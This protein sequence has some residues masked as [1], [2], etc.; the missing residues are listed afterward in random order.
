M[1]MSGAKF[2]EVKFDGTGNF[3]LWQTRVKD[4]LAQ[5]GMLKA[6]RPQKHDSMDDE[7]LEELQQHAARTIRLCLADEITYHVMNLK[8]SGEE[9]SDLAQ[10]VKCL[11]SNNHRSRTS[12]A[13]RRSH[14]YKCKVPG[15]MKIDCPKLKR[16]A[17]EKCDDLSKS[18][19]VVHNDNSDCYDGDML[20]ISTN[21]FVDAWILDSGCF[22]HITPNREWFTSCRSRNFGSVYLGD[23]RCCNIVGTGEV[24]IK[25]YDSTIRTL[26]DVRHIPDLKKNLT[27]FGNLHKNGFIPKDDEDRETIGIVKGALT[28]MK[29]KITAGNIYKLL[30]STVQHRDK[31]PENSSSSDTLQMELEPHPVATESG[32]S[33]HPTSGGSTID[34]LQTYNLDRDRP[35]CTNVKPTN[36]LGYEDMGLD[37]RQGGDSLGMAHVVVGGLRLSGLGVQGQI[38]RGMSQERKLNVEEEFLKLF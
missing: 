17:D 16:R 25:M 8:S 21:D 35:R 15:H 1:A 32:G 29:V 3:V 30:G 38:L 11:Q 20:S 5:Q 2:E 7:D 9:G 36:R 37:I 18:A 28:V 26:C 13:K 34:E 14:C 12:G 19:N 27:S 33:S 24:R 6:L 22:Y 23:D 4:L 10:H 31:M